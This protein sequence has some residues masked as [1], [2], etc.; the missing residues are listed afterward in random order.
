M[1]R[2]CTLTS[3]KMDKRKLIITS[4][5]GLGALALLLKPEA[6]ALVSLDNTG[7]TV[8]EPYTPTEGGWL[9]RLIGSSR[10]LFFQTNKGLAL[11]FI[12]GIDDIT[13]G[14]W[15]RSGGRSYGDLMAIF[16]IESGFDPRA[17]KEND[18]GQGNHAYGIGQVLG[19]TAADRGITNFDNL[20]SLGMGVD[21]TMRQLKWSWEYLEAHFGRVPTKM[22]WIGSYNAGVGAI[23]SGRVPIWYLAKYTSARLQYG[24]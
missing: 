1:M 5:I 16:Q 9:G 7:N 12:E 3:R 21:V 15:F 23:S 8:S 20:F 17:F 10:A 22:E 24:S 13:Y 18:G 6:N 19:S 11:G 4:A 14:G 2:F